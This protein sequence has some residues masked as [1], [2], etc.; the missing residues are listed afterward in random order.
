MVDYY[1]EGPA[2]QIDGDNLLK[3]VQD[4]LNRLVYH[5][6][7]QIV[8]ARVR[9]ASLDGNVQVR[10]TSQALAEGLGL[11]VEFLHVQIADAPAH[12]DLSLNR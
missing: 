9:K 1:H 2:V 5:D 8:D 7:R 4:A 12:Q 3:P 10:S 11:G 6:G